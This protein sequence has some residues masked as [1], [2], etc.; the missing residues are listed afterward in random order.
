M[1][2][3]INTCY[4][5]G[6][7]QTEIR[8]AV[9]DDP[10]YGEVQI[11]VKA[12]GI[13][14]WDSY[15]FKGKDLLEPFPFRFGHEAVGIIVE[16][17]EGVDKFKVG[18]KVFCIDGVPELSEMINIDA[19]RATKI[20][21]YVDEKDFPYYVCEPVACVVSGI[22][23]I[24]IHPGDE[25]AIIGCGYMGLLNVQGFRH[26]LISKLVCFETDPKKLEL[27]K[28][29][30]AD[31]CC[32][33]NSEEG[34][35]AIE[36]W[37]AKGGFDIVVEC[38]GSVPGFQMASDLVKN[39]GTISNF[40]WHR[41]ERT[42]NCTPWHLKGIEL[43]NTSDLRDPYFYAQAEKTI[44]LVNAGI[45]D[46]RELITHIMPYTDIQKMLETAEGHTD[47]YIKGVIIF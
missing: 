5:I 24:R 33:S 3:T 26:S 13:C 27:A 14:A 17:G 28:K 37:I 10:K 9:I 30:G 11:A 29:F 25:V 21:D 38:S 32:L 46:Q 18:D 19:N 45:I 42:I 23:C 34:K 36:R 22:N 6:E 40:A 39:A 20:P 47:G 44:K 1:K 2:K 43:I 7:R 4:V 41:G 31:E 35:E 15:L 12:C 16:C 8:Q